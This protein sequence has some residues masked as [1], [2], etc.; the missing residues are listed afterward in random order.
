MIVPGTYAERVITRQR[1][2]TQ[3]QPVNG[4]SVDRLHNT[5]TT[6]RP[7]AA[8][9][10]LVLAWPFAPDCFARKTIAVA[11]QT[12]PA[13]IAFASSL[14]QLDRSSSSLRVRHGHSRT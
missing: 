3:T 12:L 13:T 9:L 6:G 10:L 5:E 2:A 8:A 7:L 11:S 1:D 4:R 14:P